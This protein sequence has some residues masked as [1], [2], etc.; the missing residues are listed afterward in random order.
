MT[1]TVG[2]EMCRLVVCGP[3]RHIEVAVPA[4][5]VLADL[6]P[7]LLHHLGENLADTGLLH[8]GWVLQ[9]LGAPPFDEDATIASLGLR[10]GDVVHLR[11]R[12]DQI[13]PVDFDDLLDGVA[14]GLRTRAGRWRP[15]M[16]RWAAVG[17]LVIVLATGLAA[18]AMPGAPNVRTLAAA[19]LA[20]GC[21]AAAVAVTHAFAD[22][23]LSLAFA[24]AAIGYAGLCGLLA[25]NI[26]TGTYGVVVAAPQLFTGAVTVLAAASIGAALVARARP[27]FPAVIVAAVIAVGAVALVAFV[28][29][30]VTRAAAIV[31]VLSTVSGTT[32]PLLAFRL[33]GLRMAPLP[34]APEHL[35]EEL[36]PVSSEAVLARSVHADRYMTA[37]YTG[38]GLPAGVALVLLGRADDA[39]RAARRPRRVRICPRLGRLTG[40]QSRRDQVQ[41][42]SYVLGRLTAALVMAEP[43]AVE[44]PHRRILVGTVAGALVAA[45]AVAGCAVFG[46]LRPGGASSWRAPGTVV[47]EKETGSRYVLVNGALRPI[48]NYT[49]AVLLFGKRPVMVAVSAASLRSVPR[50]V[51]VG[52]VGAPDALPGPAGL[53]GVAWTVCAVASRDQAGTLFTAT[54]LAADRAP[55]GR[56]LDDDHAIAVRAPGGQTFLIWRGRRFQFTR[57]WLVR[58]FGYDATPVT[59]EASWLEQLPVGSDIAPMSVPQRGTAGPA[60]DG[61]AT[62]IGQLFVAHVVGTAER[63]YL[64]QRDGLSQLSATG[65]A[66]MSSDP[67]T[68]QAYGSGPVEPTELTAAALSALPTSTQPAMPA[69]LPD[70]PPASASTGSDHVWCTRRAGSR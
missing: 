31:A 29:T 28:P 45:L 7:A 57:N 21:L 30:S 44:N 67:E 62:R 36:D 37:L 11:P 27:V 20:V 61:R 65:V 40:M 58:A 47:V 52:I 25:P 16:T 23:P 55:A 15:D 24:T 33:S 51:P 38:L 17:L 63:Y 2:S 50:G 39:A 1:T 6:L 42:Q 5:V 3:D 9:R 56:P 60:V 12:S 22:G 34:T 35:Q 4:Q 32:V 43:E 26:D 13:P 8:G 10:D 64:L 66:V 46:F 70:R 14:T 48:L 19:G 53:D 69:D 68:A 59:V 18:L 41:A 49:S 54:T